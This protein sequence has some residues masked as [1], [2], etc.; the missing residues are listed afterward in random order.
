MKPVKLFFSAVLF[1]TSVNSFSQSPGGVSG[2]TVWLKANAGVTLSSSSTPW[3]DQANGYSFSAGTGPNGT[4][5]TINFNPALTFSGQQL[6]CSGIPVS[7]VVPSG[8]SSHIVVYKKATDAFPNFTLYNYAINSG[9]PYGI[10]ARSDGE[11]ILWTAAASPFTTPA[12]G[13]ICIQDVF[14]SYSGGAVYGS[15]GS[16]VNTTFSSGNGSIGASPT[17]W[18]GGAGG[19]QLTSSS[20]AEIIVYPTDQ[21]AGKN[22][23][24]SYLATKYGVSLPHDYISPT[25]GTYYNV[26]TTTPQNNTG[27]LNDITAIGKESGQAL[28]QEQSYSQS[29]SFPVYI[30]A[31]STIAASNSAHASTL[32]NN[33][34]L[35]FGHNGGTTSPLATSLIAGNNAMAR[36]WKVQQTGSVGTV[37]IAVPVSAFAAF[38]SGGACVSML[39]STSSSFGAG[40]YT[41]VSN[42]GVPQ[43]INGTPC[44]TFLKDFSDG[45]IYFTF[46]QAT[47]NYNATAATTGTTVTASGGNTCFSA[48]GWS[49]YSNGGNKYLG[50]YANNNTFTTEPTVTISNNNSN[51]AIASSTNA[52]SLSSNMYTID[53]SANSSITYS[54]PMKVRVYFNPADTIAAF[55]HASSA[56]TNPVG[57]TK[58]MWFKFEGSAAAVSAAQVNN[59]ITGARYLTPVYG[60]EGG[61][62]YAEFS[63]ITNFSTFGFM[64]FNTQFTLPINLQL[65]TGTRQGSNN[66]FQWNANNAVSFSAFQLQRASTSNSSFTTIA[67]ISYNNGQSNYNYTDLNVSA[68]A[69]YRLALVDIDGKISYSNTLFIPVT[70]ATQSMKVSPNPVT[71]GSQ[72]A[73]TL[74]GYESNATGS[75]Y[76]AFGRLINQN[77]LINGKNTWAIESLNRG[78]YQLIVSDANGNTHTEKIVVQ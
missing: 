14:G 72:I 29:A 6:Q 25:A 63:G 1:F 33:T 74:S 51:T 45:K 20:I 66:L 75:L 30:G 54:N 8:V 55:S 22:N 38:A 12:T 60:K 65:F 59:G 70:G 19:A 49:I 69:Y 77:K 53:N 40:T 48:D 35:A 7:N 27:Y 61:I 26:T 62:D 56:T 21:R 32:P 43:T 34:Y 64:A 67:T 23:I 16:L 9:N 4:S 15:N 78:I 42:T 39:T 17:F 47:P 18:I 37:M 68:N 11:Q 5:T 10:T 41:Q 57:N 36:I 73:I 13:S 46:L 58:S 3:V 2:V 24:E 50:I 44:V 31:G 52:T 71:N 76:D 28:D